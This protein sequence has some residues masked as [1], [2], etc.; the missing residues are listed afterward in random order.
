M[1]G[2]LSSALVQGDPSSAEI[3]GRRPLTGL[4]SGTL[5]AVLVVAGL[6]V[7]GWIVPGG[8]RAFTTAG[9]ILVENE[10]GNRYVYLDGALHATPNLTS[11]MLIQ[12]RSAHVE[13]IS[14]A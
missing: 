11:A 4:L 14:R 1:M 2:R 10:T 8:S 13:R 9:A 5:I 7:Y 3:P 12:G 6:A